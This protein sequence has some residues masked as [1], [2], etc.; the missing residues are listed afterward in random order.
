MY[1]KAA[2]RTFTLPSPAWR[3]L[4]FN[5]IWEI[6]QRRFYVGSTLKGG[7]ETLGSVVI[8][9][10]QADMAGGVWNWPE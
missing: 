1:R 4:C 6:T 10:G 8:L 5:Q 7:D 9:K 2:Q 3:L